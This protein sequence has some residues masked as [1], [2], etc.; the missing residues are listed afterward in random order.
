MVLSQTKR[1]ILKKRYNEYLGKYP[2]T[3]YDF[4]LQERVANIS[5]KSIEDSSGIQFKVGTS[6]DCLCKFV[7][8]FV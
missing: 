3:L 4:F 1:F 6:H 7:L 8:F 2:T 5:I